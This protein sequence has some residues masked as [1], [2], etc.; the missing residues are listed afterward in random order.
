[1]SGFRRAIVHHRSRLDEHPSLA[2]E[3]ANLQVLSNGAHNTEHAAD[4][5][6]RLTRIQDSCGFG[7]RVYD[8]VKPRDTLLQWA[9]KRGEQGIVKV[10]REHNARSIDGLLAL[11]VF[12]LPQ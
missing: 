2:L 12:D 4:R 9:E 3:Q 6:R 8:S 10:K 1:V 7:V 5:R 11:E